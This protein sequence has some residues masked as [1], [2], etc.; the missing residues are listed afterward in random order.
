[1]ENE[2]LLTYWH[3]HNEVAKQWYE[4]NSGDKKIYTQTDYYK[5]R[6]N[7]SVTEEGVK[8]LIKEIEPEESHFDQIKL[9][10]VIHPQEASVLIDHEF[11]KIKVVNERPLDALIS[12]THQSSQDCLQQVRSIDDQFMR[13]AKDEMTVLKFN[14]SGLNKDNIYLTINSWGNETLEPQNSPFEAHGRS[15]FFMAI[16]DEDDPDNVIRY[17]DIHPREIEARNTVP[18]GEALQK[19]SSDTF[20]LKL[21]WTSPHSVDHIGLIE[22]VDV[23]HTI[24]ELPLK[25]ANHSNGSSVLADVID[26]D[27]TYAHTVRGDRIDLLFG[28]PAIELKDSQKESYLF[29]SSGYYHSLRTFLYPEIDASDSWIQEIADYVKELEALLKIKIKSER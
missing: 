25:E 2:V 1:V 11:N 13:G 29:V 9:L 16:I 5:L 15:L 24:E 6:I 23:P 26:K 10:R 22:A 19:I 27:L 28:S 21:T 3:Q 20:T 17:R 7:P 8:L 4:D 14:I 12:C 18:L